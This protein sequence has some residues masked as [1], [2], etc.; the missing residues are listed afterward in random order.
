MNRI[1]HRRPIAIIKQVVSEHYAVPVAD[2]EGPCRE[3]RVVGARHVAMFLA[4]EL[5]KLSN[6]HIGEVFGGRDPSSV[7]H[8]VE[9]VRL[10]LPVSPALRGEVGGLMRKYTAA[11][12][13]VGDDGTAVSEAR[14]LSVVTRC[15]HEIEGVTF[16]GDKDARSVKLARD[17]LGLLQGGEV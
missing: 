3:Q 11:V 9:N 8:A 17:V 16:H 4:A 2:L 12:M 10:R 6:R 5:L 7:R 13:R 1:L 15:R 14:M